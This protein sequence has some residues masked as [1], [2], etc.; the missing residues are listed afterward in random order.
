MDFSPHNIGRL[1]VRDRNVFTSFEK[2][3]YLSR[4]RSRARVPSLPPFAC[5]ASVGEQVIVLN[6]AIAR[7]YL[8][9]YLPSITVF[10]R[11]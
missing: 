1:E 9:K 4:R 11:L 8:Y 10:E 6:W 5:V 3:D 2:Y 7:I